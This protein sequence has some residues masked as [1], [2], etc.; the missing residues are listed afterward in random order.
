MGNGEAHGRAGSHPRWRRPAVVLAV[1]AAGVIAVL[2]GASVIRLVGDASA[3]MAPVSTP[4]VMAG[5]R[6]RLTVRRA[7]GGSPS[8]AEMR[9]VTGTL[10][11]RLDAA[12]YGTTPLNADGDM[13]TMDLPIDPASVELLGALEA[14][15]V[16]E[17]GLSIVPLGMSSAG[18]PEP[19]DTIDVA[20]VEVLIGPDGFAAGSIAEDQTGLPVVEIAFTEEAAAAFAD[21]TAAHVGGYFALTLD[22]DVLSVPMINEAIP[23]GAV[24]LS[25]GGLTW[26]FDVEL[27][28]RAVAAYATSG[29]LPWSVTLAAGERTPVEVEVRR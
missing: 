13:L 28:Q 29:P 4:Q 17:G 9:E 14:M 19:G 8:G 2:G 11:E 12:G 5:T 10:R 16:T 27:L 24:Q 1:A 3:T 6:V 18:L 7:D 15:L 22:G 21:Y 20:S 25:F 23:G 26:P